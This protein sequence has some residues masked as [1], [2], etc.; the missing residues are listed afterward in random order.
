MQKVDLIN[1]TENL[2]E[3]IYTAC[4]TCTNN[5][6]P[7]EIFNKQKINV[8]DYS[9]FTGQLYSKENCFEHD[10]GFC[11]YNDDC[12][13]CTF[14]YTDISED[15]KET[16]KNYDK[17][18]QELG[19]FFKNRKIE[20]QNLENK[21]LKLIK[22][23][24]ESGHQSV[25]EHAYFTFTISGISRNCTQQLI[26]HRFISPSQKSQRYVTEK[27]QFQYV[28][29][30]SIKSNVFLQKRYHELM[31]E[32]QVYY[33]LAIE[34]GIPA[35]DAR[36]ILPSAITSS[37]VIS[38]NLRELI[39]VANERLCVKAQWE[40]RQLVNKMCDLVVTEEPWLKDYLQPKCVK[41]KRCNEIKPCG[42]FHVN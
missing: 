20:K 42:R 27:G 40:I 8:N 18:Q 29:P 17:Y 22:K 6:E 41:N 38:L 19:E 31:H 14:Q 1:H 13:S 5:E 32:L 2:K 36:F 4:K 21:Q 16:A 30:E 11:M 24:I 34:K 28:T 9:K 37:L 25:L 10:D 23:V 33:S 35:E 39:H 3:I 26:R 15:C 12:T 7:I